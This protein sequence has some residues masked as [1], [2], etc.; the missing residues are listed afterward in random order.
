MDAADKN[1]M[2]VIIGI[3][4]EVSEKFIETTVCLSKVDEAL[5]RIAKQQKCSGIVANRLTYFFLRDTL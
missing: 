1:C 4:F 3:A 2:K 5:A